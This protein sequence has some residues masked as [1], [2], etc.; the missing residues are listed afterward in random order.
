MADHDPMQRFRLDGRMV[1]VTGA[2][3]HLGWPIARAIAAAGGIP[4][5]AGRSE[6]KLV[7]L[8]E[9]VRAAGGSCSTLAFDVGVPQTCRDAI[10]T[11]GGRT[12]KLAGIV[13]CAY[14]GKAA[15]V[16]TATD[17]DFTLACDQNL[18]GPF[19]LIQAALPLLKNASSAHAGGAS[20][21]NISSMYGHVSPDPRIYGDSGKNNPPFYGAAKAGLL[22]LTR[23]LAVHLGPDRIRVNSVSPGPFPPASIA[24][25]DPA[26]HAQLCGKTP[27]GRIGA[28]DELVGPVVFL[29]SDAASFVTG[30][31]VPVDGGWT[32]W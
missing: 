27:L 23:Y 1:L 16:E 2:S 18:I 24:Q 14:G 13:N 9:S 31:D 22:Q 4:V 30:A 17:A 26:F 6:A 15:T 29:L 8:A 5:L 3:G 11:L 21:V 12:D 28:A 20:I 32:A 19:A 25:T 10:A 7:P